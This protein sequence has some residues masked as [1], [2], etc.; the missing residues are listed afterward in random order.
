MA[1]PI[2]HGK[3]GIFSQLDGVFTTRIHGLVRTV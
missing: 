1:S 3:A 2:P